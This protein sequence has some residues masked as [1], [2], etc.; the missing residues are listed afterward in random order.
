MQNIAKELKNDVFNVMTNLVNCVEIKFFSDKYIR[1]TDC[2]H[3][4]IIND[5]VYKSSM[6]DTS[7]MKI[8]LNLSIDNLEISGAL[9]DEIVN[10]EDILS[11]ICDNAKIVCFMVDSNRPDMNK[12]FFRVGNIGNITIIDNKFFAEVR[13]LQQKMINYIGDLYSPHCRAK[14]GDDKCKFDTSK[15]VVNGCVNYIN[16]NNYS[17]IGTNDNDDFITN[18]KE[19][20]IGGEIKFYDHNQKL[21]HTNEVKYYDCKNKIVGLF[22]K[23]IKQISQGTKY[24]IQAGCDKQIRT[25]EKKFNNAINFRGEPHIPIS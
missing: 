21:I 22:Y 1:L 5:I 7:A 6:I 25:C 3:D 2:E 13:G 20:F 10:V 9:V 19:F 17:F 18:D 12:L 4:I 16:E 11:G 24:I 14:L 15:Y 23:L 8:S